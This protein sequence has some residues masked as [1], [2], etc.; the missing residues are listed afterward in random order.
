[1]T[2]CVYALTTVSRGPL[3][4]R[5]L[6]GEPL[7]IVTIERLSAVIGELRA[8]PRATRDHLERYDAV[9]RRLSERYPSILPARFATCLDRGELVFILRSRQQAFDAALRHVRGRAQMTVRIVGERDRGPDKVRATRVARGLSPLNAG[10]AAPERGEGPGS[11]PSGIEYLRHRAAEAAIASFEPLRDA[12][13]RWV[14]DERVER[15][16]RIATVYHLI[17]RGS[18]EAYR[19]AVIRRANTVGLTTIVSGPFPPYAFTEW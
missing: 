14:R 1:M 4:L 8:A 7:R 2:L 11:P 3:R 12:V 5:G 16:E 18:A 15:R 17:P 13:R 19:R 6:E 9:M 10:R